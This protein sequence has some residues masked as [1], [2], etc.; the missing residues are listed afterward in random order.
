[1]NALVTPWLRLGYA[2]RVTI[3]PSRSKDLKAKNVLVTPV[4][5]KIIKLFFDYQPTTPSV[6][7]SE[8]LPLLH[9]FS[10]MFRGF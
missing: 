8:L 7:S 3:E 10:F 1:L 2:L 5:P 6:P 9:V 4:T